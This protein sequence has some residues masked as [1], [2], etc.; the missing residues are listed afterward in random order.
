[1][2]PPQIRPITQLLMQKHQKITNQIYGVLASSI[3]PLLAHH[4]HLQLRRI[5]HYSKI[6]FS[7]PE[8]PINYPTSILTLHYFCRTT[9]KQHMNV[10]L[11]RQLNEIH[12]QSCI[13]NKIRSHFSTN[14]LMLDKNSV[15]Y[16]HSS[17]L[18]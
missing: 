10:S 4:R 18:D 1:M 5:N 9:A 3:E 6:F 14:V 17:M 2:F 16:A 13:K 8:I 11:E 12:K 15:G 7:S